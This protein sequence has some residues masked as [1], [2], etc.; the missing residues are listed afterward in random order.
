L[1]RSWDEEPILEHVK[2]CVA[3]QKT[4]EINSDL[5]VE[6][7]KRSYFKAGDYLMKNFFVEHSINVESKLHLEL[8]NTKKQLESLASS[9]DTSKKAQIALPVFK[10]G[11]SYEQIF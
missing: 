9:V 10:W 3:N 1:P 6:L 2:N 7:L 4:I 11:Q 8:Q 5:L